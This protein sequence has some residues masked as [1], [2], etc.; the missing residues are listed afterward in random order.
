MN[1][2]PIDASKVF[3]LDNT[4]RGTAAACLMKYYLNFERNIRPNKGST[5]LRYGS[6]WHE[7]MDAFYSYIADNGWGKHGKAI[8]LSL[9]VAKTEWD[10]YNCDKEGNPTQTFYED[11]RSLPNL[12]QALVQYFNEYSQDS[13]MVEILAS[14]NPYQIS[15][16]PTQEETNKYPNLVPFLFTGIIDLEVKLNGMPWIT[17]HK[18]TGQELGT[19]LARLNRSAQFIG[20]NWAAQQWLPI[21]PEG[22]LIII[23]H[24]SAYKSKTTG[25]YGNP[26]ISFRRSPQVYTPADLDKWKNSLLKTASDI[27]LAKTTN[28]W[29]MQFDSCYQFG[30]CTYARVCEQVRDF[31]DW[32]L[33]DF[34]IGEEWDVEALHM[35][36]ISRRKPLLDIVAASKAKGVV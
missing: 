14:E 6:I 3:K 22:S 28:N 13:G 8:Q 31:D 16:L 10:A 34:H 26:K 27:M 17:D 21:R 33:H 29:P 2:L 23:H 24:L 1:D 35:D 20:Y 30:E 15:I 4:K 36:R 12:Y 19:Q 5:A 7:C 32:L 11:Y 9:L 25:N 18:T